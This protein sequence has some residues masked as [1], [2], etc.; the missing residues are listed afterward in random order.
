MNDAS[1]DK[2][3]LER[4][5]R[6][7]DAITD[8]AIYMLDIDGYVS[9]W[10]PGA[11]RFKGYAQN[12][13]LGEHFSR[14]YTPE[15]RAAG[16]PERALRTAATEGRFDTEGWRVRK[17]GSRF[18]AHV[19][20]DP[21]RDDAGHVV[22]FAKITRDLTER[23]HAR[24]ALERSE[25]LFRLLVQ[26]VTDY[27]IFMLDPD[28]LVSSWNAGA[29][30][31]KGYSESE[32]VGRHFSTFYT[33][34]D[35]LAGLPQ[36]GLATSR[37][38]G[39]FETEGL[40][41]RQDGSSFIAHVII[42]ALRDPSGQLLGYAKV[43][44]DVTERVHRQQALEQAQHALFQ[45]QKLES[46]GQLTGG[47]AHD[48]NNLL[49]AVIGSLELLKKQLPKNNERS[50]S[51][52]DNALHGAER[53]SAL[54]QRMLSFARRQELN[55]KAVSLAPLVA[56]MLDMLDRSLGPTIELV[57]D[58]P[59]S[60]PS[61]HTDVNQ[62]ETA[63]LNL[64]LNARDAMVAGG[65][66]RISARAVSEEGDL[67]KGSYVSIAVADEGHGMDATTLARATEP[68][69]TTKGVGKGT[70]LGLS[71][72]HGLAEQSGGRLRIDSKPGRGTVVTMVFPAA[73]SNVAPAVSAPIESL[74]TP[75]GDMSQTVLLV[76]DDEL[77]LASAAAIIEDLGYRVIAVESGEEA[78][79]IIDS[80]AEI[81]VLMTDQAMPGM[82]GLQ[83]AHKA[84]EKRPQL[85]VII[86]SGFPEMETDL[87]Q[88]W[89]RLPKP[90]RRA[91]L[92]EALA[93]AAQG[94]HAT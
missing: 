27:A 91:E 13:I 88:R 76:D 60:L 67:P 38:T 37:T 43:T 50:H 29:E 32:I 89:R 83:L 53:G 30:R 9:S 46:I 93:A 25:N 16:I 2:G 41:V 77:V 92:A 34:A 85:P 36:Q 80:A 45:T 61:V 49:T 20:I 51:L 21:I 19:V 11:R 33:E 62:L 81:D 86:A 72:V 64:A 70:G 28:G 8:Y 22:G 58:V 24:A 78:L 57:T 56:G 52:L 59:E 68:F 39:R 90:F 44:R 94:S 31:I 12:E 63:L 82:T 42:D 40:R 84:V 69:F 1:V 18:W 74:S 65:T 54:T 79:C 3:D 7:I 15:D 17:D 75:L 23:M 66:I 48:F 4:Y 26:G 71:M 55:M 14:F 35:R 47:I 6:L 5:R 87:A 73:R 10:N